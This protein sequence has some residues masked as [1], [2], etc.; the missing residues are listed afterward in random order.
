MTLEKNTRV[1]RME[2]PDAD[3]KLTITFYKSD[4]PEIYVCPVRRKDGPWNF[5]P[6]P[7]GCLFITFDPADALHSF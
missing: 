6:P 1:I 2:S 3:V 5:V 4:P 7:V